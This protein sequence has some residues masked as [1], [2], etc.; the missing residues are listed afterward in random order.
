MAAYR[1][2]LSQDEVRRVKVTNPH[3]LQL[4]LSRLALLAAKERER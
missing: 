3:F 1:V 4:W 2:S